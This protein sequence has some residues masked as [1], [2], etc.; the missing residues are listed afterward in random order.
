MDKIIETILEKLVE[1]FCSVLLDQITPLSW[2][3][4]FLVLILSARLYE[5][6][7]LFETIEVDKKIYYD[8]MGDY[9]Y[10]SRKPPRNKHVIINQLTWDFTCVYNK[11]TDVLLDIHE[12]WTVNF[13]AAF[14]YTVKELE[15]GIKGGDP[16]DLKC[17][18]FI[19]CQDLNKL[20]APKPSAIGTGY[21]FALNS[22]VR[23]KENSE[24]QVSFSWPE[25]ILLNHKDDYFFF[26]PRNIAKQVKSFKMRII[27]P[28]CCDV[29]IYLFKDEG[30]KLKKL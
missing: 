2:I 17:S 10:F 3:L 18:D 23:H 20:S 28:Y 6:Y 16:K 9:A 27:H 19:A 30:L 22:Y 4:A 11:R 29:Q 26:V 5:I 7:R 24:I 15:L 1:I 25:F 8:I 13:T 12:K 14:P 21:I